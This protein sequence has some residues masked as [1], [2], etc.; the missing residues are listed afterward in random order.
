MITRT[1]YP[2]PAPVVTVLGDVGRHQHIVG[3][4]GRH[5]AAVARRGRALGG[6][7]DVHRVDRIDPPVFGN[8][9]VRE[10][11]APVKV[12]VT[13]FAPAAAALMFFA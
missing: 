9:N 7:R 10:P 11:A 8:P 13:A 3:M 1:V 5:R 4:G 6:G 2:L 12:T